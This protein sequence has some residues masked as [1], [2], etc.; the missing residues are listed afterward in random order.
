MR[1][2]PRN[3]QLVLLQ[4][5]RGRAG[6][7]R[8]R[9]K[10]MHRECDRLGLV[11]RHAV[12][13]VAPPVGNRGHTLPQGAELRG[14]AR[15]PAMRQLVRHRVP[16]LL[17]AAHARRIERERVTRRDVLA[18][19]ARVTAAD[20]HQPR[21]ARRPAEER[22]ERVGE[23]AALDRAGHQPDGGRVARIDQRPIGPQLA[24]GHAV[25]PSGPRG[26]VHQGTRRRGPEHAT[27]HPEHV[28]R[29]AHGRV[30]VRQ[31]DH[32][33][34]PWAPLSHAHGADQGVGLSQPAVGGEEDE[35][36][37]GHDESA[38][39]RRE[40]AGRQESADLRPHRQRAQ[41]LA[42]ADHRGADLRAPGR[43]GAGG[44]RSVPLGPGG[45]RVPRDDRREC[46]EDAAAKRGPHGAQRWA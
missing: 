7:A 20:P 40:A 21:R 41:P 5:R 2:G 27:V 17:L 39:T 8:G 6:R 45:R 22:E 19:P 35:T 13:S 38:R 25:E 37:V 3:Q 30:G 34:P 31:R 36:G 10:E 4:E 42:R 33:S 29:A 24:R 23:P 11:L 12:V 43:V 46:Q 16:E 26:H 15:L 18:E 14:R 1:R 32:G 28:H 44:W 9:L